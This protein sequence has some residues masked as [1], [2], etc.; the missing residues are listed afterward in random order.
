MNKSRRACMEKKKRR[1]RSSFF[2]CKEFE[3]AFSPQGIT[4]S[5]TIT[6]TRQFREKKNTVMQPVALLTLMR[7]EKS[8]ISMNTWHSA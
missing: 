2:L 6:L 4:L 7:N 3:N 8:L 1:S 5:G